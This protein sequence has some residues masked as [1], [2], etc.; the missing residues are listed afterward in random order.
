ML[1]SQLPV[2]SSCKFV[3]RVCHTVVR[4]V[5]SSLLYILRVLKFRGHFEGLA[6]L[7]S[8][9]NYSRWMQMDSNDFLL[10]L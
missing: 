3:L 6:S 8:I 9:L 4:V 5:G 2:D 10:I 7:A 1:R